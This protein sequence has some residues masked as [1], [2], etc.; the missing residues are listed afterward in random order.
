MST[1]SE[2]HNN[3]KAIVCDSKL[4][5]AYF[6]NE[7][8]LNRNKNNRLTNKIITN[9][10]YFLSLSSRV[11]LKIFFIFIYQPIVSVSFLQKVK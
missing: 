3:H 4:Q 5:K 6:E 10:N 7:A 2:C 8:T 9:D 11:T 1:L